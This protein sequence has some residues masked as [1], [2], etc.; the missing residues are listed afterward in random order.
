M[1]GYP[2]VPMFVESL[3]SRPYRFSQGMHP[4][5]GPH[6]AGLLAGALPAPPAEQTEQVQ[7]LGIPNARFW[8]DR[9]SGALLR[10]VQDAAA[11]EAA[12]C[13]LSSC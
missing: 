3:L 7:M 2:A 4:S 6:A 1:R 11:R 10:E 13:R 12:T 5:G 8:I 9:G